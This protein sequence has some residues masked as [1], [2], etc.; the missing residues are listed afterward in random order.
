MEDSWGKLGKR[1]VME[2]KLESITALH[3]RPTVA[4][5]LRFRAAVLDR[6]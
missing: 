2:V 1:A 4:L 6:V 3:D 5:L